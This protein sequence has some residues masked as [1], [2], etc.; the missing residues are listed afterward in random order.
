MTAGGRPPAS[1]LTE[2]QAARRG[3]ILRA[4]ARLAA[5]GGFD[6]VQMRDVAEA[7]GVALGTLYRY[8]PSKSHLLAALARDLLERWRTALLARPS[9]PGR[10][11]GERVAATLARTSRLL[12]REPHLADA[13]VRALTF[14]D[15][16]AGSDGDEA[17]RLVTAIVL[18]AAGATRPSA[19]QLSAVRVVTHTWHAATVAELTGRATPARAAADVATA[20]GLIDRAFPDG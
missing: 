3:A 7:A 10:P 8:F 16:G 18:D 11:P 5:R 4:G 15:R 20:C 14:A 2:R 6:A 9:G 12:R 17:A 19:A 13:L 1:P